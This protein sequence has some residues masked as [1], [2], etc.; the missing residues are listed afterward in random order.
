[1][2]ITQ[3]VP[4]KRHRV[5]LYLDGEYAASIDEEVFYRAGYAQGDALPEEALAALQEET[6]NRYA[7]DRALQILSFRDHSCGELR[8]KL[9]LKGMP[10]AAAQYAVDRLCELELLDDTKYAFSLAEEL[11]LR[12][13]MGAKR[14]L[15]E[16]LQRGIDRDTANEAV[17]AL[18]SDER[19]TIAQLLE[20]K[21]QGKFEDEKGRNRTLAAL[22]RMG[23]AYGDIRAA[24]EEYD[25]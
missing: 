6:D 9:R 10:E 25:D 24:L 7:Y 2:I 12:R 17:D 21:F 11:S 13:N 18:E 19:E 14:I 4:G 15:S 23:Y 8:Q 3:I 22:A 1:M 16:L 20:T 5:Y